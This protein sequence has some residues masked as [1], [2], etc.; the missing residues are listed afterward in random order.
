MHLANEFGLWRPRDWSGV[1]PATSSSTE[2]ASAT[3]S[4]APA[5][6][7]SGSEP[8]ALL[9]LEVKLRPHNA[10]ARA[11]S[12]PVKLRV[13][14]TSGGVAH[15]SSGN[16]MATT[17]APFSVGPSSA[18]AAVAS[19]AAPPQ[20]LNF[21]RSSV[22]N[23]KPGS[24]V[25]WLGPSGKL[26]F[27][28]QLLRQHSL[29]SSSSPSSAS[30]LLDPSVFLEVTPLAYGMRPAMPVLSMPIQVS[31][32]ALADPSGVGGDAAAGATSAAGATAAELAAFE[33]WSA[34]VGAHS[35]RVYACGEGREVIVAES[36]GHL[37]IGGKVKEERSR[38]DEA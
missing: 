26:S 30:S 15:D 12:E 29:A 13:V 21:S 4:T 11:A 10:A 36:P 37:G 9:P 24:A 18:A 16:A 1:A 23:G 6:A 3:I 25:V 34:R 5:S 20:G 28:V 17:D 31:F 22:R 7:G 32:A 33:K 8:L 35:C 14:Q 19:P 38:K 2:I 27:T